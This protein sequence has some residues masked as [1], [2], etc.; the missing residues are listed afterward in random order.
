MPP[1][2]YETVAWLRYY[3]CAPIPALPGEGEA[4]RAVRAVPLAGA[5]IGGIG[6]IVLLLVWLVGAPDF[7]A[8]AI[9]VLALVV[10]TAGR[11]ERALA[12]TAEKLGG[13]ELSSVGSGFIYYG[14][15][16]IV[17]TV[18]LRAGALDAL[19]AVG[20]VAAGIAL[21]GAGAVSRSAAVGFAILRPAGEPA[22]TGEKH[23]LQ[24]LAIFA[25]G[26]GIVTVLPT[27]GVGATIAGLAAAIGAA[28]LVTAFVPR[29]ASDEDRTFTGTAEIAA[30]VAFLVAIVAFASVP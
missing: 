2:V 26:F 24:W 23:S 9:A 5:I 30:E 1:L 17:L 27:Y 7:V 14:V 25:L 21:V 12:D 18:L 6:A 22:D 28:S 15:V 29:A 10:L 11:S 16:A 4:A 20:A 8:A 13:G 3:T 19:V